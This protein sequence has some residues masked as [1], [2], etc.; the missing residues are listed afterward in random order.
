VRGS[1]TYRD[2]DL[3]TRLKASNPEYASLISV[4]TLKLAEAQSLLSP[5]M[6]LVSYF[7]TPEM[8]LAFVLT[9]DSF[10]VSILP[11]KQWEL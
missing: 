8:T 6:T 5:D 2:E 11:V 9:R 10:H 7:V 3:L 1:A 4:E